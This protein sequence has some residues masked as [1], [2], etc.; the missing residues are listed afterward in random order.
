MNTTQSAPE[1]PHTQKA[2]NTIQEFIDRNETISNSLS[3]HLYCFCRT[4]KGKEY[5]YDYREIEWTHNFIT[6]LI[7]FFLVPKNSR[8]FNKMHKY[9]TN[10]LS[11]YLPR[12]Q[13]LFTD[14]QEPIVRARL[15]EIEVGYLVSNLTEKEAKDLTVIFE[16]EIELAESRKKIIEKYKGRFDH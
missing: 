5:G 1:N 9:A 3:W 8:A 13:Q 6:Q 16:R 10:D 7:N 14:L 11:D 12:L 4:Q 2:K 15:E